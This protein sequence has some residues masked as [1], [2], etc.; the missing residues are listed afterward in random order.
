M[1]T[2]SLHLAPA[3]MFLEDC[4]K[5]ELKETWNSIRKMTAATNCRLI[6]LVIP[7]LEPGVRDKSNTKN[8]N[9]DCLRRVSLN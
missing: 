1:D 9:L 4:I 6:Q 8:E 5:P 3:H 2:D 7:S